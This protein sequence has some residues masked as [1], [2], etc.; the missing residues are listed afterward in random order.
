[1]VFWQHPNFV[2]KAARL[3]TILFSFFR[4]SSFHTHYATFSPTDLWFNLFKSIRPSPG[5]DRLEPWN[6]HRLSVLEFGRV[7][8]RRLNHFYQPLCLVCPLRP[9]ELLLSQAM[10]RNIALIDNLRRGPRE[11]MPCCSSLS[12][13]WSLMEVVVKNDGSSTQHLQVCLY[14]V[15]VFG[16]IDGNL[17]DARP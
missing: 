14:N 17:K 12:V 2:S 11:V 16:F 1:M 3:R 13:I 9:Q 7:I 6:L 5:V 15:R 8:T 4:L 10:P